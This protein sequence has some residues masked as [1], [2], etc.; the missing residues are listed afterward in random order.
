VAGAEGASGQFPNGRERDP[1]YKGRP[2]WPST[3]ERE[4]IHWAAPALTGRL[5]LSIIRRIPGQ[6]GERGV[7]CQ[8]ELIQFCW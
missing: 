1:S 7:P 5:S 6:F 3:K 2:A 4:R 8:N